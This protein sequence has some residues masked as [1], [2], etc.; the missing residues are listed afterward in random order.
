MTAADVASR[1]AP[2]R[3]PAPEKRLSA[4]VEPI[5]NT[6]IGS[7]HPYNLSTL[8]GK[9]TN[10]WETQCHLESVVVA[11]RIFGVAAHHDKVN[12]METLI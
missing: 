8:A 11:E 9:I 12:I 7:E 4:N 3:L 10:K 1:G 6:N 2:V 5:H